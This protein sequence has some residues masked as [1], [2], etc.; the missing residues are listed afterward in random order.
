MDV[1]PVI[2]LHIMSGKTII[3]SKFRNKSPNSAM[4]LMTYVGS[5]NCALEGLAQRGC[6]ACL[7]GDIVLMIA[8]AANPSKTPK[9]V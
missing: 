1:T 3:F 7:L 9:I 2:M 4:R 5:I 6:F 8:P